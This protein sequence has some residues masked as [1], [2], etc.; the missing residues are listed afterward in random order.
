M[1]PTDYSLEPAAAPMAYREPFKLLVLLGLCLVWLVPGLIGHDPWK[2]DEAYTFGVIFDLWKS[3]QPLVP[4][5]AGEPFLDLN[6]LFYWTGA[7]FASALGHWL[8]L[9]DAA[10]LASGF[11]MLLALVFVG[12]AGRALYGP[13]RGRLSV[14]LLIGCVG[15]VV[16]AHE[17]IADLALLSGF[18]AA[19]Y[20]LALA[21]RYPALGGFV[22]G[23]G[24]G[25]AFL[26]KG[27]LQPAALVL[28]IALAPMFIREFRHRGFAIFLALFIVA[29]LPWIV[30]WPAALMRHAPVL[31]EV[32]FQASVVEPF[33][34]LFTRAPESA[35][36]PIY[37][38]TLLTWFAWPVLP[39]A[40]WSLWHHRRGWL[41][42]E[43]RLPLLVFLVLLG[44]LSLDDKNRDV[45]AIPLLI[46][47]AL[48]AAAG[49][50]SLRRGAASAL[51]WFGLMT[52]GLFATLLWLGWVAMMTGRPASLAHYIARWQNNFLPTFHWAA[53]L[54]AVVLTLAWL[55]LVIF[56]KRSP[57]RAVSNWAAGIT[58]F[59]ALL[60]TIWLPWFDSF[61][62]YRT[63]MTEIRAALPPTDDCVASV[64]LGLPQRALLDYHARLVT[65]RLEVEPK[66]ECRLLLVQGLNGQ[67]PVLGDTWRQIWNGARASDHTE[68]FWLYQRT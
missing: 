54:F 52:F 22:A 68:H 47:L 21:L 5:L 20:G 10:R 40:L 23:T 55:F 13:S 51:D 3:G 50:D 29:L 46:P 11:Y 18:A 61:K 27:T 59:W 35:D 1:Y 44:M 39:L 8:P 33:R 9:H 24:T 41:S 66:T 38:V 17:T 45:L 42:S 34:A 15:L 36:N 58:L 4:T 16:H 7:L 14:L 43:L 67:P 49:I 53:F 60:A 25:V 48:I 32:W 62:S 12:L 30:V 37:Y 65:Q 56:S 6:P 26:S 57:R 28:A 64:G 63:L 2:T 31:F 19:V